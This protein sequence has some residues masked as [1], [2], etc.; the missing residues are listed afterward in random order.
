MKTCRGLQHKR[1]SFGSITACP[2]ILIPLFR[3]SPV[4]YSALQLH[5]DPELY[6]RQTTYSRFGVE[7]TQIHDTLGLG[8]ND[9]Y[10]PS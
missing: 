7:R 2:V 9:T 6:P 1:T 8:C 4:Y 5:S 10:T 3:F